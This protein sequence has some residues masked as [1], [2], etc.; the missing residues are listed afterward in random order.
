MKIIHLCIIFLIGLTAC[1]NTATEQAPSPEQKAIDAKI[2]MDYIKQEGLSGSITPSGLF[3]AIEKEGEG[4][5]AKDLGRGTK[6]TA[7][8]HGTFLDGKVFDSSVD[9]GKPFE[10]KLGGVIAGWQ[11][12]I[13]LLKKGGKGTFVIPS[14][15]AYGAK[16]F[17][18]AI[19]ANAVLRF[20]V[21]L[22]DF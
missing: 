3:V 10:F 18:G 22:L 20:G 11:E 8:Y 2:I 21:E 13:K 12:A 14:H 16:G 7:H 17:P 5:S 1:N 19:P 15:L 6:V 9:R 4:P